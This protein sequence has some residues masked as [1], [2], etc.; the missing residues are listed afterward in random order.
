MLQEFF[1]QQGKLFGGEC[2]D[3]LVGAFFLGG[4]PHDLGHSPL[5]VENPVLSPGF[6][7]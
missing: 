4:K 2:P 1:R 3:F 7:D 6:W 5:L